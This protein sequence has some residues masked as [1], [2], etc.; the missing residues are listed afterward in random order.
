MSHRGY[1]TAE[2]LRERYEQAINNILDFLDRKPLDLLNPD[3][4]IRTNP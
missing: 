1:A 3:A 4:H 2:V